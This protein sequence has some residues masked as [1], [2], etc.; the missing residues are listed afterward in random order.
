MA[1]KLTAIDMKLYDQYSEPLIKEMVGSYQYLKHRITAAIAMLVEHETRI[2]KIHYDHEVFDLLETTDLINL[3]EDLD[4]R[5]GRLK[6]ASVKSQFVKNNG[7]L[8][9]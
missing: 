8:A 6:Q 5:M 2:K 4:H 7:V 1:H 3:L 9:K